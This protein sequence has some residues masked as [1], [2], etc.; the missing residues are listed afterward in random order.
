MA[1]SNR[2]GDLR[3]AQQSIPK[4]TI[5]AITTTSV[6]C[7]LQSFL[8]VVPPFV[9]T[10]LFCASRDSPRRISQGQYLLKFKGIFVQFV[11]VQEK[12]I[13][14][15]AVENWSYHTFLRVN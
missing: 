14:A 7:I 11:T 10:R 6:V 9:S 15:R 8:R 3:D 12:K 1:G 5:A 2:S 13:L 4:G